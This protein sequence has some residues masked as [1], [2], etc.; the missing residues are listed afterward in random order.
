MTSSLDASLD[1]FI[2]TAGK[3]TVAV[4]VPLYG[5]WNDVQDN[6]V[7]GEV[8]AAVM[9]RV[10]SNV[11]QLVIVF[12]AHPQTLPHDNND[13]ES[14]ANILLAKA[15]AGNVMNVP[16]SRQATYAEYISEG[17]AAVLE[18]TKASFVVVINPWILMQEGALDVLVDRTNF[19]DEAKVVSG[20]DVRTLTEPEQFD[21]FRPSAP[22]EQF[23]ISLD[24]L[25]I[26][27]YALEMIKLDPVYQTHKFLERDI[28]QQIFS[29]GFSVITSQRVPIFPFDFPWTSYETKDQFE[30]DRAHFSSKWRFD[31]GLEYSDK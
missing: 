2:H 24:L 31:A 13:S 1:R 28:W 19:G 7:N 12:V 25:C 22:R 30:A 11:H 21:T 27:R 20:F 14:V 8:L 16:V 3:S 23:D 6:P 18:D 17:V 26:P 15:Q 5:Y 4:I 29:M 9:R 10:Y